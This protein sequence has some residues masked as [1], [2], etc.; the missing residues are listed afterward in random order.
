[1]SVANRQSA[2]WQTT[3]FSVILNVFLGISWQL[4]KTVFLCFSPSALM[5]AII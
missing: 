2:L 4:E 5:I 3:L 1:M